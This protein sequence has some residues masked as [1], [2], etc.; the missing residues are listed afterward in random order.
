MNACREL[1]KQRVLRADLKR[2]DSEPGRA[3]KGS[4]HDFR[5]NDTGGIA[6]RSGGRPGCCDDIPSLDGTREDTQ[7]VSV[8][9]FGAAHKAARKRVPAEPGEST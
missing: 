4:P 5:L 8:F 2:E 1:T 3:I 9:A 7:T 6:D